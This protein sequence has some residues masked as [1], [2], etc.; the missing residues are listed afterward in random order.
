MEESTPAGLAILQ[1]AE[2]YV[3]TGMSHFPAQRDT[4]AKRQEKL[5]QERWEKVLRAKELDL[6]K[7]L[8]KE[9]EILLRKIS[10]VEKERDS[11]IDKWKKEAELTKKL[12]AEIDAGKERESA[13]RKREGD[14]HAQIFKL[15]KDVPPISSNTIGN[16]LSIPEGPY[17]ATPDS[18]NG[19]VRSPSFATP[20]PNKRTTSMIGTFFNRGSASPK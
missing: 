14:L 5:E 7:D 4:A 13:S 9:K 10:V 12:Q 19:A 18:V 20:S 6:R 15:K 1:E 11:Y 8:A 2:K 3:R 16:N 17:P